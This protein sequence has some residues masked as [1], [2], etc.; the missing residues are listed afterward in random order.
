MD[1]TYDANFGEWIRNEQNCRVVGQNIKKY[2]GRYRESEFITV[3]KWVVKDWTLKSIILFVRKMITD[4]LFIG[5]KENLPSH[6][7]GRKQTGKFDHTF[8][9][10]I[11]II[12]GIIFTWN[13]LFI[14]EFLLSTAAD[15]SPDQRCEYYH[16]I[17]SVFEQ[18]KLSEIL[19]QI[20]NK[21]DSKTKE[22]L[23]EKFK[24]EI[25]KRTDDTWQRTGS[26]LDAMN[27]LKNCK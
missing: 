13:S 5:N 8:D 25:Y 6:K 4:D 26:M 27:L 22:K 21:I 18:K 3:I 16:K 9:N 7:N 19:L 17:L 15:F 20:E 12:S 23:V 14:A 10:K 1:A 11:A 2:I 24:G